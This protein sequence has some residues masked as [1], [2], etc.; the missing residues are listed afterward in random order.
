M[1]WKCPVCDEG[2]KVEDKSLVCHKGH[3]F[4][5]SKWGSVNVLQSQKSKAKQHGDEKA[6]I[7]ARKRFLDLG[8]YQVFRDALFDLI[9]LPKGAHVLDIGV[10]EGYYGL[11]FLEASHHVYGID[12][13]KEAIEYAAKRNRDYHLAVASSY[14]LPLKNSS[15]DAAYV[16]FAPFSIAEVNRVLKP[17]GIFV[18]VFPLDHHLMAMKAVL[19]DKPYLNENEVKTYEGFKI[20][21]T[22]DVETTFTLESAEAIWDLFTMTPYYHRT[23]TT[24]KDRLRHLDHLVVDAG[25]KMVVYQKS[26]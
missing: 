18:E 19:Y 13:S 7:V 23:P 22:R 25:F 10:G 3:R 5:F 16:V 2:L 12:I 8:H 14:A 4:D 11:P 17:G 6:M 20:V 24:S 26:E 15:V 9:S 1:I 21:A